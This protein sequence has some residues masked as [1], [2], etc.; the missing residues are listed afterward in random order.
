MNRSQYARRNII[1]GYLGNII[2]ALL[3]FAL[4]TVFIYKLDKSYLGVNG[5]YSN[6]LSVL[7]LADLGMTNAV[8]YSLYGPIARKEYDK[9]AAYMELFKKAYRYIAIAVTAV[10]TAFIPFLHYVIKDAGNIP[11][12]KLRLYYIMFLINTVSTYF[13]AYKYSLANAQQRGY[14]QTNITTITKIITVL[15]QIIVLLVWENFTL[16]LATQIVIE[17]V[18]KVFAN[19]YLNHVYPF[20]KE[21]TEE[22]LNPKEKREIICNVKAL[23]LHRIGDALRL[24]TDNIIISAF[25]S[26]VMVG[27][28]DNYVLVINTISG[29]VNILFYS[30]MAGLGNVI[31]IESK[32]KQYLV[33]RT[34]RFL[35]AWIYGFSTVG[36]LLLLTPLIC[37]LWGGRFILPEIAIVLLLVDYYLK[38]F[39]II[40]TNYTTAAGIFQEDRY[41]ALIQGIVNLIISIVLVQKIG[42]TGIYIGTVISGLIANIQKPL[43]IYEKCF[44]VS[45]KEYFFDSVKYIVTMLVPLG[46]CYV[47]KQYMSVTENWMNFFS[48]T[49]IVTTMFNG[50]YFLFF[51]KREE[52]HYLLTILKRMIQTKKRG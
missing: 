38:G 25:M 32:E 52:Y 11:F 21:R 37:L 15:A 41:V 48:L 20:L 22:K 35:G 36:Y 51:H 1:F 4:R 10:G 28:V 9:V 49:I 47:I 26:V 50:C 40:L 13:V 6:I 43:M 42:L 16:Y 33:F 3:G 34:Y 2:A 29:F 19:L 46:I 45:V 23:L 8:N 18:Q 24:Q 39:R 31:A 17:L 44:D 7:S 14:I 5:L 27:M 12:D 30:V